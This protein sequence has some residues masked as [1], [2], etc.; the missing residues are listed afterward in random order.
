[1]SAESASLLVLA[2]SGRS[3][4]ESAHRGGYRVTALDRFCDQDT[5]A[6]AECW[7]VTQGFADL[8]LDIFTEE[9]ASII[10]DYPCGVVYGAGLEEAIPLLKRLSHCCHL[11]G[12]DPSVLELLRRPRCF[13]SLLDRLE[14]PYPEVSFIAP[15]AATQRSWLIKRAGSCGGQGVAY[16]SAEYAATD[17]ACYYQKYV[18]GQVMSVLFIA[19]GLRHRTIGYNQL[20]IAGSNTPAPFLYSGA[21]GQVSPRIAVREQIEPIV[22]QLVCDLGLRGINSLDFIHNEAGNFV[23]DLNPRPTATL[24]LYEHLMSDGWIKQHILACKNKLPLV[25]ILGSEVMH[26]HQIV[27]ANQTHEM[28]GKMIWPAWVKDRPRDGSTVTQG[29]PICSLYAEGSCATEVEAVLR[30]RRGEIM[31]ML[32]AKSDQLLPHSVAV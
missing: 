5:Q 21:I 16:F 1:M 27:Y 4:A 28:P 19:D 14:I 7:P 30:R 6:V 25:P 17:P 10:P 13:F 9:I 18:P 23:I 15:Y 32:V 11:L 29:Q 24:E 8:N 3:I 2:N 22:D 12:N 31:Q 20:G 26:G